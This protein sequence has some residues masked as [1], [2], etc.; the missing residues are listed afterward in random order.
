MVVKY[1]TL[2]IINSIYLSKYITKDLI[3]LKNKKVFW[4]SRNLK[5]PKIELSYI[6]NDL[7]DYIDQEQCSFYKSFDK[8]HCRIEIAEIL[9]D[10]CRESN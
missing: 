6:Q 2:K 4:H 8:K 10:V 7:K 3:S 9:K 5:K 1:S